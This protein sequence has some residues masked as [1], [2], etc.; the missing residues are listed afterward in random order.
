MAEILALSSHDK[1]SIASAVAH[2][3]EILRNDGV[4]IFPTETLYGIAARAKSETAVERIKQIKNRGA[5]HPFTLALPSLEMLEEFVPEAGELEKRLARRC[6]PGP[7]TLVL[8]VTTDEFVSE[9]KSLP[10][11]V[12]E[13][14]IQ[15]GFCGFRMPSHP[16]AL[17][18]L[19]ELNEPLI[20]T[21]VNRAGESPAR[22]H[23]EVV[24]FLHD[25]DL[26]GAGVNLAIVDEDES[27]YDSAHST[28]VKVHRNSLEVLREGA[29]SEATL[30]RLA[31]TMI[32]FVC[33]GNTCR[34][35]LAEVFCEQ[36]LAQRLGCSIDDLESHGYFVLSAG[37]M[38][39]NDNGASPHAQRVAA[40][41]GL[42][43]SAHR[44]QQLTGQ[45]IRFADF[46][47]PLTRGHRD[48]ILSRWLDADTRTQI[49]RIDGRDIDDPFGGSLADYQHCADQIINALEQRVKEI[50]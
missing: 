43:L 17:A 25:A 2:A 50:I 30:K 12:Q 37:V 13:C 23:D 7:V 31:T 48:A 45:H 8:S 14:V 22:T 19:E 47:Y 24:A 34:S 26:N 3:V 49:L 33:T 4:V 41:A 27:H 16:L 44:S 38:A 32:L 28:V 9:V 18:I 11:G 36:L 39:A 21:S 46:I 29:I 20:L 10:R 1:E 35:P 42:S 40:D 6:F 5:A 15:D